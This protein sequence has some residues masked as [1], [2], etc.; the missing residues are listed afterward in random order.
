MSISNVVTIQYADDATTVSNKSTTYTGS[1]APK[2]DGTVATGVTN[3]LADVAFVP[4][5]LLAYCLKSDQTITINPVNP[6]TNGAPAAPSLA[7]AT[8]GGTILAGTYGVIVTYVNANGET[9]GSAAA[10]QVTTGSTS[11]IT[12]TAP[13]SVTPAA[14]GWYAYVTQAGGSTYTRQQAAGSPTAIGSNLVLTAPPTST[15]LQPQIVNTT[16]G[17]ATGIAVT[18]GTPIVFPAGSNNFT[19]T[20]VA[21]LGISNSSG[22]TANVSL[23]FLQT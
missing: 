8:T 16:G 18:G 17:F 19:G 2:W 9:I 10:S 1:T 11:T 13:A 3:Q 5:L 22:T 15:G 23:R 4:S 6:P 20:S 21:G 7:T 14:T 12:I